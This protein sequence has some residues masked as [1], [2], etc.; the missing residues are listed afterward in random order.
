MEGLE[1]AGAIVGI[2]TGALGAVAVV[3]QVVGQHLRDRQ[4]RFRLTM[5]IS[6]EL[7]VLVGCLTYFAFQPDGPLVGGAVIGGV[8]LVLMLA[9]DVRTVLKGDPE[10]SGSE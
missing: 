3:H 7:A 6:G 9:H 1:I 2:T 10:N 8:F 4:Q 5:W